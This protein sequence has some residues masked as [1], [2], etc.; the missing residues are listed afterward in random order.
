VL[1]VAGTALAARL[2]PISE[3]AAIG[4]L[5]AT[6]ALATVLGTFAGGPLVHNFG[7]GIVPWL[8]IG[9]LG[10]AGAITLAPPYPPSVRDPAGDSSEA[11]SFTQT[12]AAG[13]PP[14]PQC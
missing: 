6:G 1:S 11:S 9:G 3:G 4:L 13:A 7:Y 14:G 5:S 10:I 8:A 2:T 12:K